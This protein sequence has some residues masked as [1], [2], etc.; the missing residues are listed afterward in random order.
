MK[1]KNKSAYSKMYLVTPGVY[2]KLLK[3][4]EDGDKRLTEDLNKPAEEFLASPSETALQELGETDVMSEI[5][6]ELLPEE[7]LEN[8]NPGIPSGVVNIPPQIPQVNPGVPTGEVQIYG[9]RDLNIP[10]TEPPTIPTSSCTTRQGA[11][12]S[13]VRE[14]SQSQVQP[15]ID[16]EDVPL[17]VRFPR[18]KRG[19][20]Y[21]KQ[22]QQPTF[23]VKKPGV[24][25]FSFGYNCPICA[26][27]LSKKS[28]LTRHII[29]VHKTKAQL[30]PD[31]PSNVVDPSKF[32]YTVPQEVQNIPST[33]GV[34]KD[35]D[36]IMVDPLR[37]VGDKPKLMMPQ[38]TITPPAP[39]PPP[40]SFSLW[41]KKRQT[42]MPMEGVEKSG[43]KRTIKRTAFRDPLPPGKSRRT[44]K[45]SDSEEEEEEDV[46]FESWK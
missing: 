45:D 32:T 18:Q 13:V 34:L 28:N 14:P 5:A 20:V 41:T 19:G 26:K 1:S 44:Q 4:L 23:I 25:S 30:P 17:A 37:M 6:D 43:R 39:P 8:I 3:C 46:E 2:E 33:F 31:L 10:P 21:P 7:R 29:Q 11:L 42:N 36:E 16:P 38:I 27:K 22:K 24:Q 9:P 12:C 40:S 35:D 15:Q